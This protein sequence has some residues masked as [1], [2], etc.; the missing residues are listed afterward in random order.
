[1]ITVRFASGLAVTYNDA[2]YVSWGEGFNKLYDKAPENG[3]SIVAC[4]PLD[5]IVEW[6]R[7][8]TV[9]GVSVSVNDALAVLESATQAELE[10][11]RCSLLASVKKRLAG[12]NRHTR[13]WK[14]R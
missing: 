13:S 7:P 4:V 10:N 3:G 14:A 11:G 8:C 6:R 9:A 2:Y 1:M 12:F 5:A